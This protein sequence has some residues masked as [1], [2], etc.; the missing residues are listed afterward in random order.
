M[1]NY[2]LIYTF[3]ILLS[4]R[5]AFNNVFKF[6]KKINNNECEHLCIIELSI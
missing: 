6:Y 3:F 4:I 5:H 1:I 2:F